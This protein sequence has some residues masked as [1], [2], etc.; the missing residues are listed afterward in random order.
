MENRP[1]PERRRNR[2]PASVPPLG[3][4][5]HAKTRKDPLPAPSPAPDV[6]CLTHLRWDFVFQRPQHLLTRFARDS[7]VFYVEEPE[8]DD[9]ISPALSVTLR[10]NGVHVVV[11]RL[12][13]GLEAEEVTVLQRELL[14]ELLRRYA[15]RRYVLW[16]YTPMALGFSRHLEP[17][18]IVYDCMD[19]L[20]AFA[21]AP[22]ALHEREAELLVRADLVL[23]GGQSLYEAKQNMHP[24]VH[25]FPSSVDVKHFAS[26][27]QN[28]EDPADQ[29]S[30]G[31]PRL[32]FF[33]VIDERMDLELVRGVAEA[34][35]DWQLVF[36]GPT[37]KIDPASFPTLPNVHRLGAKPYKD[38]PSYVAGWDVALLP[39]AR[40]DSTK[41][42]SPTKTPE[43]LAAG[44]PVV[45]TSIRDVV[46]PYGQQ[47]LARIADTIPE[48]VAAV[49]A[50]LAE[51][52]AER[53]ARADAFLSRISWERTWFGIRR[54]L[55]EA[56][57]ARTTEAAGS[58]ALAG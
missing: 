18:S 37:C 22:K 11:P 14:D 47:G 32:G 52:P 17:L 1:I 26:A 8:F 36:L 10:E 2:V 3:A 49:E 54:L 48:F 33:G 9:G 35:P 42:I 20:S 12:P 45:S 7:R 21:G 27:R 39:F 4:E 16:Y 24:N 58:D 29:A 13:A 46:R 56:V 34:R 28:V 31:G 51:N 25:A 50:A 43:Y 19:E 38:L 15:I 5:S 6:V 44:K 23:T 53:I 57:E 30:I 55:T 40:N 41:F